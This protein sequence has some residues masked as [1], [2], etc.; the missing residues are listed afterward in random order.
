MQIEDLNREDIDELLLKVEHG[1]LGTVD[2]EGK[3]YV[4]PVSF[5][6]ID[7]AIYMFF[8]FDDRGEKVDNLRENPHV[9]FTV[10]VIDPPDSILRSIRSRKLSSVIAR[11]KIEIVTDEAEK[12]RVYGEAFVKRLREVRPKGV[13]YRIKPEKI[14]GRSYTMGT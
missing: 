2:N 4:V 5:K 13:Y 14:T 9:C 11:G 8:D 1:D 7:G 3:P 6:Y 10:S 12:I